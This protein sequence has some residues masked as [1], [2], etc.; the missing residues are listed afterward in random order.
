MEA[1][2][3]VPREP[4][5]LERGRK[6][7]VGAAY[8]E[9]RREG[10]LAVVGHRIV[11]WPEFLRAVLSSLTGLAPGDAVVEWPAG[12]VVGA[13]KRRR[14]EVLHALEAVSQA[15]PSLVWRQ[16][17][18]TAT[19]DTSH[20]VRAFQHAV[21]AGP[22]VR[23]APNRMMR[24]ALAGTALVRDGAGNPAIDKSSHVSRIDL[25]SAAVIAC[26]IRALARAKPD[27]PAF[28]IAG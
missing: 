15:P 2:A 25:V 24:L 19:E 8:V 1:W 5:L 16:H 23:C 27:R 22:A 20:D 4:D 17:G 6:D 11:D 26:G 9:A 28:V 7:G 12:L 3:A 14:N 13:D 21:K 10:S 18:A